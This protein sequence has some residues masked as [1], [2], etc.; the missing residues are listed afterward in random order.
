M[1][2]KASKKRL[3]FN[4]KGIWTRDDPPKLIETRTE[5]DVGKILDWKYKPPENRGKGEQRSW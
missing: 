1:N 4:S 3:L 5:E 2:I